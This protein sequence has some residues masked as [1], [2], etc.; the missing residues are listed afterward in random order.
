MSYYTS[1]RGMV[2][3]WDCDHLGHMNVGH[4]L[5]LCGDG[6]FALQ[7][8]IGLTAGDIRNGRGL[9][10]VVVHAESDFLIEVVAGEIITLKTGVVKI[11][12]KSVTFHH[13]LENSDGTAVFESAFKT[14][15]FNTRT[16]KADPITDEIRNALL[17]YQVEI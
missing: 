8:K 2:P 4:Y 9:S 6:A 15:L 13:V 11:G 5:R 1:F 3:Q 16:R 14:V 12:T 10:F 7:D 17:Y